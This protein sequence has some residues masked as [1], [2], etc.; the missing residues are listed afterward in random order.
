L[1][2]ITKVSTILIVDI[3]IIDEAISLAAN[4][5]IK[6][7]INLAAEALTKVAAAFMANI[8]IETIAIAYTIKAIPAKFILE[9]ANIATAIIHVNSLKSATSITRKA[10][11]LQNTH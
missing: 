11:N 4:L 7:A 3:R 9:I 1:I 10:A 8:E 2:I 6:S 5:A